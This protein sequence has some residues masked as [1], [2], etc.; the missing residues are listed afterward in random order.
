MTLTADWAAAGSTQQNRATKQDAAQQKLETG[1]NG[2]P[3]A[4]MTGRRR[5]KND[6]TPAAAGFRLSD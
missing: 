4:G 1:R 5:K 6:G 2:R 3:G